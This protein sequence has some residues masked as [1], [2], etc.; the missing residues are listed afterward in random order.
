MFA[1]VAAASAFLLPTVELLIAKRAV[2]VFGGAASVWTTC[3]V[4]S[5]RYRVSNRFL[6]LVPVVRAIAATRGLAVVHVDDVDEVSAE[7][8]SE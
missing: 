5:A 3:L 8:V 4:A 1:I 6:D 2:V 7:S